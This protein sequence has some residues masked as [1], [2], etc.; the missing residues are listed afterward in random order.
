[1]SELGTSNQ[2][3]NQ[4][5]KLIDISTSNIEAVKYE[6]PLIVTLRLQISINQIIINKVFIILNIIPP[7]NQ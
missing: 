1:V 4:N 2:K 5:Q 6:T 3:I 7:N